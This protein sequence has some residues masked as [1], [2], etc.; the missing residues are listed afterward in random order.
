MVNGI[1]EKGLSVNYKVKT[2]NFPGS[3]SKKILEKLGDIIKKKLEDLIF[4]AGTNDIT[5]NINLSTNIKKTFNNFSKESPLTSIEF[6]SVINCK[7]KT[8]IQKTLT[9]INAR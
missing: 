1:S 9:H 6:S 3:T 2:V 7:N 8:N 4:H 5:N